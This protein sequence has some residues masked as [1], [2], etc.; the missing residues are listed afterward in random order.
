MILLSDSGLLS[1][2]HGTLS[3]V[4]APCPPGAAAASY[5]GYNWRVVTH[6]H[7]TRR[8]S[9]TARTKKYMYIYK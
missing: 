5:R 4:R 7:A 6:A 8:I 2:L 3:A 9:Q 1:L